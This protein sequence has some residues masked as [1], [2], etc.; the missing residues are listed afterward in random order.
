MNEAILWIFLFQPI[1]DNQLLIELKDKTCVHSFYQQC[2][3]MK[4]KK[5]KI[6]AYQKAIYHQPQSKAKHKTKL[7]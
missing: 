7:I 1:I 4:I 5:Y 6:K 2:T 3:Y